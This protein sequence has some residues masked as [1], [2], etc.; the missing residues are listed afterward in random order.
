MHPRQLRLGRAPAA[1][2]RIELTATDADR[3]WTLPASP[4]ATEKIRVRGPAECLALLLWGR[5]TA[6][7]QA[8]QVTGDGQL[9]TAVLDGRFVP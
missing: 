9:L 3:H 4:T 2:V 8:L 6:A 7:D 1:P 5:T